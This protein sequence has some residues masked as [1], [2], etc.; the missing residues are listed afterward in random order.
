MAPFDGQVASLDEA[1][2]GQSL[3]ERRAVGFRERANVATKPTNAI[4]A[5]GGLGLGRDSPWPRENCAANQRNELAPRH[6]MTSSARASSVG[7]I[8]RPSAFA[9][10][11]L[12]TSS[13][14]VGA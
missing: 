11:R 8:V 12:M 3:D 9:V 7:G 6:S 1:Q 13:N 14:L 4:A 10:L 5:L 2:L